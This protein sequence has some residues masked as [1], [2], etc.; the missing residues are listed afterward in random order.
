MRSR[1]LLLASLALA[2]LPATVAQVEP[3]KIGGEWAS[4][5]KPTP[6]RGKPTKAEK[7][8]AKRARTRGVRV[9]GEGEVNRGND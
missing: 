4:P 6:K 8:A 1:S 3:V 9:D 5:P 2:S 7:K